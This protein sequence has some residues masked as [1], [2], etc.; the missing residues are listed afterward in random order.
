[1]KE[2]QSNK[3]YENYLDQVEKQRKLLKIELGV[4]TKE[5]CRWLEEGVIEFTEEEAAVY[6]KFFVIPLYQRGEVTA[7]EVTLV[8]DTYAR[9]NLLNFKS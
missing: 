9:L 6:V 3:V 2:N 7:D 1:M 8:L 5:I 4:G